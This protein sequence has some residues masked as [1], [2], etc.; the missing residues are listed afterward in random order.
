MEPTANCLV[1]ALFYASELPGTPLQTKNAIRSVAFVLQDLEIE[2]TSEKVERQLEMQHDKL[3]NTVK[4]AMEEVKTSLESNVADMRKLIDEAT[5]KSAQSAQPTAP[6]YRD[7]L[8]QNK[9]PAADA[10]L[11]AREGIRRRQI[12][13]D[14]NI[15]SGELCTMDDS[16]I[17]KS[18]NEA[19]TKIDDTKSKERQLR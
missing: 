1:T 14:I 7:V 3:S 17:F 15:N 19:I 12:L 11:L 8:A 4:S 6:T 10:R 18:F 2:A 9:A 5:V 16:A 13:F